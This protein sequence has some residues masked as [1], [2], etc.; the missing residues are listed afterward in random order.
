MTPSKSQVRQPIYATSV[1]R[2]RPYQEMLRPLLDA[3]GVQ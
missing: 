2:W 3:L 1:G